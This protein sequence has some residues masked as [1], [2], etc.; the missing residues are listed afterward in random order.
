M[1]RSSSARIWSRRRLSVSRFGMQDGGNSRGSFE[2]RLGVLLDF[3]VHH[4][5]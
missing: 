3:D 5:L 1:S 4:F 2:M